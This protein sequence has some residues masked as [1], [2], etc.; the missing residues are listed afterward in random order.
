MN[1]LTQ[2]L[3]KAVMID[4]LEYP[5]NTSSRNCFLILEALKD[6]D[7]FDIEKWEILLENFYQEPYPTN[8]QKA[9]EMFQK[10]LTQCREPLNKNEP[11][12]VDFVMDSDC[13]YDALLSLG[14]SNDDIKSLHW[15]D[16]IS[17][18]SET[19]DTAFN[20]RV[21]LRMQNHRGKLTKEEREEC[22]R[23]GW[24]IIEMRNNSEDKEIL[25][26]LQG[27]D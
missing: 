5:I 15:W 21:Y 6:D 10:F 7:L 19:K 14:L 26:Y 1:R 20:R 2:E 24:D 12:F 11:Q 18:L 4:G 13:I 16:F 23:I 27:E 22:G 9:F 8:L 25:A 17:R 3:P